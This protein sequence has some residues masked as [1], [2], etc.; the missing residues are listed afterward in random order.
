M[1]ILGLDPGLRATGWGVIDSD[2]NRLSHVAHGT[3]RSDGKASL[4][5]RLSQLYHGINEVVAAY[6]PGAAAVE[7]KMPD[8]WIDWLAIAGDPGDCLRGIQEQFAAGST[9]VVLCVVP[10]EELPEQLKII[11]RDILPNL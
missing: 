6:G 9:S 11:S 3:V 4:A 10:S 7:E 1:R 2:G 8:E 5:E